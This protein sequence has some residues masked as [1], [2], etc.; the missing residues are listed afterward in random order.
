MIGSDPELR[1]PLQLPLDDGHGPAPRLAHDKADALVST[2]LIEYDRVITKSQ[3][4]N[5]R[6]P[7]P[8]TAATTVKWAAAAGAVVTLAVGA[9]AARHYFQAREPAPQVQEQAPAPVVAPAAPQPE[10][11][12]PAPV[13]APAPSVPERVGPTTLARPSR[14]SER[15]A[16][17]DL[18]QKANHQR[19]VAQF[20]EA[21]ATYAQVYERFPRTQSAYAARVAGA[22]IE[23]EHLS[24]PTRAR[25]LFEQ[26]LRDEPHGALDL[27]ARQGL[28]VALRDL[29]D[30]AAEARAL[31]ALINAHPDSPAARRAQVRLRELGDN[32]E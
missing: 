14:A 12:A 22:A 18:L 16:P 21:A 27:E 5:A 30:R 11:E 10:P 19:S 28:C 4:A 25:H 31:H 15:N 6:D 3:P 8:R 1:L 20:R 17:E 26:A 2:A 23:L 32:A 9:A 29:E 13:V 24:N 7:L